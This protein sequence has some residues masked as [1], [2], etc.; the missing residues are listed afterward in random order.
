MPNDCKTV[1]MDGEGH[2]AAEDCGGTHGWEELKKQF[3]T[4][5]GG[6][7]GRRDWYIRRCANSDGRALDP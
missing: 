3:E 7:R 6:D 5:N 2:P 4:E 1:C